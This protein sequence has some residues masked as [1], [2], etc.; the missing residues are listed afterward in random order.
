[1]AFKHSFFLNRKTTLKIGRV[2]CSCGP[3]AGA[4]GAQ[5]FPVLFLSF[6]H[7][8]GAGEAP[9]LWMPPRVPNDRMES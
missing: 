6:P 9:V 8:F 1:M 2:G 7:L 3:R 5:A 4:L